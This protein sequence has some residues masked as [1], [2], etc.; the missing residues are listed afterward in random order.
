MVHLLLAVI[1]LSFIGLGLPDSLLG[2]A[3][4]SMY[5]G[6][7]VPVSCA[8]IVSMLIS[9]CTIVS[10]LFS[11]HL[12]R[13]L[14]PGRVTALSVGTTAA[15]L[16]GFASSRTF[17]S[18]CFWAVPYGLGAGSVDAVLNNFVALHYETRHMN[19]LHCFWG[20]GATLGPYVMG[21]CLAQGLGWPGGYHA[22]GLI[23]VALTALLVLSL[24]LWRNGSDGT[25]R[26]HEDDAAPPAG[27][28]DLFRLPGARRTLAAFFCYCSL[29]HVT[30]LWGSSYMVMVKGLTA[31]R[32]AS[33]IGLF[34]FGITAGRFASGFLS[35]RFDDRTMIRMGQALALTGVLVLPL[36][37][38][39]V[40]LRVGFVLI[41]LGCAPIYPSL[42]HRTPER[43]GAVAS[44]AMMGLQMACAY[45]GSTLS[46]VLTGWVAGRFGIAPYP[47]LLLAF[48][49]LMTGMTEGEN[50]RTT[51]PRPLSTDTATN[52]RIGP[53][54]S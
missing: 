21:L 1:Y 10:S 46:P 17:A 25:P 13:S 38:G 37:G 29:E 48:A 33:L 24:P 47:F 23:Q 6:L 15:A 12:V 41:G 45:L 52:D 27:L 32:A 2:A 9:G 54:A 4:P 22:V 5:E 28:R 51:V 14:G 16:F 53:G 7:A 11:D 8:G 31:D 20:V 18:I 44:Q 50:R 39:L 34:Y 19:W 42:L 26:V 36:A 40:P 3:W 30:G 43:F 35:T 49:L